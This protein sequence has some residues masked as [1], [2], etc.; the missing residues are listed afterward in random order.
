MSCENCK[1]D[2]LTYQGVGRWVTYRPPAGDPEKG[3]IKSW[4]E[5]F[6]FVVYRCGDDW[7]HFMDYTAAATKPEYLVFSR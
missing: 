5:K 3:R 4:N 7:E 2:T 1:I 6:V